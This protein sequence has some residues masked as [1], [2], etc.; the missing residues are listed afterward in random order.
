MSSKDKRIIKKSTGIKKLPQIGLYTKIESVDV[1][2]F[3]IDAYIKFVCNI[4]N[5]PQVGSY[6][7]T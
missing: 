4:K 6:I 3:D 5:T 7:L 1:N 2:D